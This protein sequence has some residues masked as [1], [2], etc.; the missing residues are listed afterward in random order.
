MVTET[1]CTTTTSSGLNSPF[2]QLGLHFSDSELR[3]TSYE[4]FLAASRSSRGSRPLTFVSS[5]STKVKKDWDLKNSVVTHQNSMSSGKRVGLIGEIMRGHMRISEQVDSRVRR[6]L[7]RITAG[8]VI[9]YP[10]FHYMFVCK[11]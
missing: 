2:P 6:A 5:S 7:L 10:L 11:L 4:I 3:E 9:L 1:H 8:Q